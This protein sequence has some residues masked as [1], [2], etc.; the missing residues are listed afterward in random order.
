MRADLAVVSWKALAVQLQ[1]D[2]AHRAVQ[3]GRPHQPI[4]AQPGRVRL[5][6]IDRLLCRVAHFLHAGADD[7]LHVVL[8]GAH[9]RILIGAEHL[10]AEIGQAQPDVALHPIGHSRRQ[11]RGQLRAQRLAAH[12]RIVHQAVD[13][14]L[15]ELHGTLA[16]QLAAGHGDHA[17]R[18]VQ[19]SLH[20]RRH[21]VLHGR[22]LRHPE[23]VLHAL[24]NGLDNAGDDALTAWPHSQ[25]TRATHRTLD[26]HQRGAQITQCLF[27]QP[28]FQLLG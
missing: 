12:H 26:S 17:P 19:L 6:L 18:K 28:V 2:R 16:G 25:G 8:R 22:Q 4:R 13:L 14:C 27:D 10:A 5:K 15:R 3:H 9:H 20:E 7:R 21:G 23:A 1:A 24:A 11:R